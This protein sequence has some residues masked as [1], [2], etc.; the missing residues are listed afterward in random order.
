MGPA[1]RRQPAPCEFP[2][3]IVNV[4]AMFKLLIAL[5]LLG[6]GFA[7]GFVV[8]TDYREQQLVD[9][10][11]ALLKLLKKKAGKGLE[12]VAKELQKVD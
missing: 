2:A 6:G 4:R 10:P 8:G 9:D 5:V 7:G 3:R 12:N 11:D 1:Y